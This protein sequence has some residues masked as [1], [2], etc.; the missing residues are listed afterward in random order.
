MQ[1]V[2]EAGVFKYSIMLIKC[3]FAVSV[4]KSVY[5]ILPVKKESSANPVQLFLELR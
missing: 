1:D 5:F 3:P 4:N 2:R